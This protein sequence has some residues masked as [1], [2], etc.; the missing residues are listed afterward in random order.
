VRLED[1]TPAANRHVRADQLTAVVVGDPDAVAPQFAARG[2]AI[3]ILA[4]EA[5]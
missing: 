2:V 3:E 5:E 1:L 4:D